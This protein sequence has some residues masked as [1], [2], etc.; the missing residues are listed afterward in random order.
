ME[1]NNRTSDK[2]GRIDVILDD[3][4]ENEFREEVFKSKGMKRG[5]ISKAIQEA[6]TQWIKSER[7]K[8]SNAAKK[9]WKTRKGEK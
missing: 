8:R 6:I 4:L 1:L 3:K 2:M 9:A 7:T 5:N